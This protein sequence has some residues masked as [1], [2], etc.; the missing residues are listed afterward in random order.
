MVGGNWVVASVGDYDG[1]RNA[2]VVWRNR[3]TGENRLWRSLNGVLER[4]V[5]DV[6]N[7]AWRVVP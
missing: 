7:P 5:T 1:N 3:A 6:R 2:E 4:P